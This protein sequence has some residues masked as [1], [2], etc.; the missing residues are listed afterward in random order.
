MNSAETRTLLCALDAALERGQR[1]VIATVVRV[2]GSAYRR[3]GTRML[4]LDDASQVCMLSGGCLE[5]E[6]VESALG[7]IESG[8]PEVV[9][10]D[11]SEDATWGLGAAVHP[12]TVDNLVVRLRAVLEEDPSR[13]ALLLTAMGKGYRWVG[14]F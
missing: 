8:T 10:Y 11:L 13:P 9:H 4:V 5:G 7:V 6:V 3:E 1:A 14:P 2:Q 12:R